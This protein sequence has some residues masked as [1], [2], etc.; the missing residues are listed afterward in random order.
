MTIE[1]DGVLEDAGGRKVIRF[2]RRLAHPV[3]RVWRALT[4]PVDL[5]GWW[6]DVRVDL[7]EGGEFTVTWLNTD[8]E[9]KGFTMH[10]VITALDPP[11]LLETSGDAHG[12]LRWELRPDGGGTELTFSSTLD[13]PEEYRTMTIA[14]WHVHLGA[15][16]DAL[17]GR[18]TDLVNLPGWPPVH[19]AYV[20]KYA[21]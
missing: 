17:A 12:V 13:L 16:A 9:G 14:G 21:R 5:I 3:D 6:G 19:E 7:V 4:D 20:A 10:A 11:H 15:L 1:A 8:D 2:R 18:S